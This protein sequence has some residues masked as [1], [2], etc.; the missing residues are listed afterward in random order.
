MEMEMGME[1]EMETGMETETE[2]ETE[3]RCSAVAEKKRSD[4]YGEVGG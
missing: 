3:G 1:I 2:T 4:R